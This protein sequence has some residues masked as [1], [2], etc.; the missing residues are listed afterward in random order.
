MPNESEIKLQRAHAELKYRLDAANFEEKHLNTSLAGTEQLITTA[1]WLAGLASAG[2]LVLIEGIAKI[3][4]FEKGRNYAFISV[5]L[6][7]TSL[8]L[9]SFGYFGIIVSDLTTRVMRSAV[10]RRRMH[11]TLPDANRLDIGPDVI[12]ESLATSTALHTSTKIGALAILALVGQAVLVI[13]GYVYVLVTV[14]VIGWR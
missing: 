12:L 14:A 1:A 5:I 8:L 2:L 9:A 4:D 10:A 6:F 13:L 3:G 7:V 11:E